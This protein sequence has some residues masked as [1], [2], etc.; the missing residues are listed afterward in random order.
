MTVKVKGFG[1]FS[2]AISHGRLIRRWDYPQS[3]VAMPGLKLLAG[4][5]WLR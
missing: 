3:A 5:L 2:I 4:L 1:P